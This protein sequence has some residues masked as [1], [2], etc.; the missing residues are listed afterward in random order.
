MEMSRED[1]QGKFVVHENFTYGL[2]PAGESRALWDATT[3]DMYYDMYGNML[4]MHRRVI[5]DGEFLENRDYPPVN[6]SRGTPDCSG[7]IFAPRY[8]YIGID[9][10][11]VPAGMYPGAMKY[12]AYAGDGLFSKTATETYWFAPGIPVE[13]KWVIEDQKEGLLFTYELKGWG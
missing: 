10:V 5:R 3:D 12:V 1:S 11:T 7:E 8:T 13:V 2:H 9:P 4:S 6:M